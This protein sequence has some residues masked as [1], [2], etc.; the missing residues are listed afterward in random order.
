MR[1]THA[2]L[3]RSDVT[4]VMTDHVHTCGRIIINEIFKKHWSVGIFLPKDLQS[5]SRFLEGF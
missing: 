3:G 4:K 2:R 1:E 5:S